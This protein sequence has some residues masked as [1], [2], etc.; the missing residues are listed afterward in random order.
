MMCHSNNAETCLL[1]F[2]LFNY[3]GEKK[4]IIN[5]FLNDYNQI[6]PIMKNMFLLINIKIN[7]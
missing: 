1:Q 2:V 6:R 7:D 4:T 3:N 5:D